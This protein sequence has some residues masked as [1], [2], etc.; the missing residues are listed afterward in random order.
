MSRQ[1]FISKEFFVNASEQDTQ[2]L[3]LQL[4]HFVPAIKLAKKP[5]TVFTTDFIYQRSNG[6]HHVMVSL[7]PLDHLYTNVT[8]HVSYANGAVFYKDQ[9]INNSINNFEAAIHNALKGNLAHFQPQEVPIKTHKKI[10]QLLISVFA[11]AG[12]YLFLKKFFE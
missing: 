2:Q 6:D 10:I 3:L 5:V 11:L 7:L 12:S 1:N 4:P 8:L 9:T